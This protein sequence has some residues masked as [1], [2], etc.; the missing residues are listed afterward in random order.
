MR[1]LFSSMP[2]QCRGFNFLGYKIG[3]FPN[4][5]Y[6]GDNG[7][8]IGVHQDLSKKECDCII[9]TMKEFLSEN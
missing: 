5:E 2:T 9:N 8:H 3:D 4:A 6:I 1:N 7:I